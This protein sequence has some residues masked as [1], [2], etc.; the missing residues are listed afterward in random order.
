MVRLGEYDFASSVDGEH[1]DVLVVHVE[2]HENY[3]QKLMIYD[4]AILDLQHDVE[5]NGETFVVRLSFFLQI[6]SLII[7]LM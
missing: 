5:F 6:S 3:D 1:Q 4:I 2:K 7:D